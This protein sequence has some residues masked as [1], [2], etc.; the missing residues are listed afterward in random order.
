VIPCS[1]S[2]SSDFELHS[3]RF[4]AMPIDLL[5]SP[6][7]KSEHLGLPMPDDRDAVSA[8]LPHWDHN[9]AYEEGDPV[10]VDRLQAAY[11]RFCLHPDVRHLCNEMFPDGA[12]LPFATAAAANR[13]VQY[14]QHMGGSSAATQPIPGQPCVGVVVTPK[15]LP[16]LK[17][18]WQYAGELVS[19]RMARAIL[20]EQPVTFTQTDSQSILRKRVADLH[21]TADHNVYLFSSGMAAIACAWRAIKRRAPGRPTCQFGFPYVDTLK[22]QERFPGATH[23]FL[24][25][26]TADDQVKLQGLFPDRR[27]AAVFCETPTNPLLRTP[28]LGKLWKTTQEFDSLLVV[29]DTLRAC[30]QQSVLPQC[31]AVVTSLTKY[32]SGYG[33]VLAGALVLNPDAAGYDS[34]RSAVDDDFE[35][36]L[37]DLDTEVLEQNSRDFETRTRQCVK[38]ARILV[39]RLR[40]HPAIARIFFP[41]DN[42]PDN[43]GCGAVFSIVLKNAESTTPEVFDRLQ[44]SKGPNLGTNF[45][46]CCPYTILAHYTELDFAEHC[47]ASRWLLR[48]STGIEPV[49]DLWHRLTTALDSVKDVS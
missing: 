43:P 30:S 15:E 42:S 17:Q 12:G 48:F 21:Q 5:T 32:F 41:E 33:N 23:A 18:Y 2:A 39:Q 34:F 13:A 44:I 7:W 25:M 28:D 36:T 24:P 31:D 11:P 38:N 49:E 14:V 45:T 40:Q 26:G 16:L 9:I 6:R 27:F 22:I 20:A 8:C 10:V 47:G 1:V 4:A 46:L 19:S 35:E 37:S 3:T 29:D